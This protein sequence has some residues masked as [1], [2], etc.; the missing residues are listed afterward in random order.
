MYLH[1]EPGVITPPNGGV[2]VYVVYLS[3]SGCASG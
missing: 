2:L 1:L 3:V